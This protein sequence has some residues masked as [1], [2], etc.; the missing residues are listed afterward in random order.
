MGE[1]PAR[2][3]QGARRKDAGV[4]VE[5]TQQPRQSPHAG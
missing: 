1:G 5:L 4:C 2:T 3:A